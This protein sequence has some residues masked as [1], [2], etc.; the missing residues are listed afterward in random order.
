MVY[1]QISCHVITM[2][3]KKYIFEFRSSVF[4]HVCVCPV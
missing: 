4:I 1:V 2:H 3:T